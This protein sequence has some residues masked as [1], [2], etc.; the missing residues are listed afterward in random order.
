[1]TTEMIPQILP[2][3]AL[4]KPAGSIVPADILGISLFAITQAMI[5]HTWQTTRPSVP[6][7]SVVVWWFR[8]AVQLDVP[9]L[10]SFVFKHSSQLKAV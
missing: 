3:F 5:P 1:M 2:A 6:K 8:D 7:T 4:P 9:Y 10:K